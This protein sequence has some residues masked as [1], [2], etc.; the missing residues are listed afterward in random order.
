MLRTVEFGLIRIVKKVDIHFD[1][2][3]G[4]DLI[5]EWEFWQLPDGEI[6]AL[7]GDE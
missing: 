6:V 4:F 3:I 5:G 7:E 2:L 1:T